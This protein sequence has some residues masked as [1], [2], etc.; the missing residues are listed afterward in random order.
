MA[1]NPAYISSI[2]YVAL[3]NRLR[4]YRVGASLL[5]ED[6]AEKLG[7]SVKEINARRTELGL[8]EYTSHRKKRRKLKKKK[9]GRKRVDW[10]SSRA[11][12]SARSA[13][14]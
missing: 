3:G 5:A 6:V 13:R 14:N 11:T 7:I 1:A 12:K 8:G 10:T 4:A 9:T 2:D